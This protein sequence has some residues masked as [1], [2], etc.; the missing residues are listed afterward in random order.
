[1][2]PGG[3]LVVT[4]FFGVNMSNYTSHQSELMQKW[5]DTWAVPAFEDIQDF[6]RKAQS[7]GFTV[8]VKSDITSYIMKSAKRLYTLFYPGIVAHYFLRLLSIRNKT[9]QKNVWSSY[10]QYKCFSRGL[11]KYYIL[12]LTK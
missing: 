2:K 1:L 7:V 8:A 11:C 5:A 4:D 3:K 10:Y 12:Q 6:V 9:Q